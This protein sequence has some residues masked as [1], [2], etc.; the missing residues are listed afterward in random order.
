MGTSQSVTRQHV[1][2][3]NFPIYTAYMCI[4]TGIF[5]KL[6]LVMA[7]SGLIVVTQVFA[8]LN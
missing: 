3:F 7:G 2:I 1:H 6:G 8:D 5:Y 4:L